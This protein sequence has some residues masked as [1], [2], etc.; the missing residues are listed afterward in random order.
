VIN[1]FDSYPF[2]DNIVSALL[3]FLFMSF[4]EIIFKGRSVGKFVTGTMAVMEDGA[5]IEINKSFNRNICRLIP[6]DGL[7]FF[8]NLGWHDSISK[9]RVV[10]KKEFEQMKIKNSSIDEIGKSII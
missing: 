3:Y 8:G 9:T 6:F 10:N 1:F 4:Q 7:S 2:L 5:E